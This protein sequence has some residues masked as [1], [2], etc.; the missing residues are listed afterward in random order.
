[1]AA[2]FLIEI[3]ASEEEGSAGL[4]DAERIIVL[5]G[6]HHHELAGALLPTVVF[7]TSQLMDIRRINAA[8]IDNGVFCGTCSVILLFFLLSLV[9]DGIFVS[10]IH[11]LLPSCIL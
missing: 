1:M 10:L 3:P 7:H 5:I 11:L 2:N 6:S 9:C 4:Y 8:F